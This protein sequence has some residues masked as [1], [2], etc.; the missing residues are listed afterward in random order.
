MSENGNSLTLSLDFKRQFC[1]EREIYLSHCRKLRSVFHQ[2]RR[3]GSLWSKE[4]WHEIWDIRQFHTFDV[5]FHAL[6]LSRHIP[7]RSL[8]HSVVSEK[9]QFII[10][11]S[12]DNPSALKWTV[13][14][15]SVIFFS[16]FFSTLS[17][18]PLHW[19]SIS[20]WVV[21]NDVNGK[22]LLLLK[23]SYIS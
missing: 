8:P 9:N 13:R 14:D 17:F 21:K 3:H 1:C 18:N 10:L 2:Q 12:P 4:S 22:R 16:F 6:L 5:L 23:L 20:H 15:T 7:S 11:I 19:H